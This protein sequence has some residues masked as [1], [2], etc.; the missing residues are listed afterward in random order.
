[1]A[2]EPRDPYAG[3]LRRYPVLGRTAFNKL[4]AKFKAGDLTA[5]DTLLYSNLRLVLG[6]A[7]RHAK[8]GVDFDDLVQAVYIA[9]LRSALPKYEPERGLQ[10]STYGGRWI[11]QGCAREIG[12]ASSLLPYRV[13]EHALTL[14]RALRA[15]KRR[16]S[17]KLG[18]TVDDE[19]V[20]AEYERGREIGSK[21]KPAWL[22]RWALAPEYVYSMDAALN[23]DTDITLHDVLRR[24]EEAPNSPEALAYLREQQRIV[25]QAL[26]GVDARERAVLVSHVGLGV[27]PR[28]LR[29]IGAEY[30]VTRERI[31]QLEVKGLTQ[32]SDI[33]ELPK[34]EVFELLE[35]VAQS[36][37]IQEEQRPEPPTVIADIDEPRLLK[38][39]SK[40]CE[41]ATDR[42]GDGHI[43]VKAPEKTLFARLGIARDDAR[44]F[45]YAMQSRNWL[46][47]DV[48]LD[49]AEIL[50]RDHI[51]WL[52]G[53][54]RRAK[55][56]L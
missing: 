1:M 9:L 47:W 22:V 7:R 10:F 35:G 43:L 41:H 4:H 23:A 49:E 28:T 40:L 42:V 20:H 8:R 16:L 38:A 48:Q 34:D 2:A 39:F 30:G 27:V 25:Q 50:R 5:R 51:K 37:P 53:E 54:D 19:E 11:K 29:E 13:S 24:G 14:R 18:R 3:T 17:R 55:R 12:E 21:P 32:L 36:W 46:R 56:K 15:I 6:A 52:A 44:S 26:E 31:R 45:L 33:L